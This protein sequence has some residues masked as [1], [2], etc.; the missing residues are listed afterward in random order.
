MAQASIFGTWY[1]SQYGPLTLTGSPENVGGH[2]DQSAGQG[3]I[4][5]GTFNPATGVLAFAYYQSWNDQHGVAGFA[6]S[7]DGTRLEGTWSQPSGHS[8]WNLTRNW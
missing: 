5:Q 7:A 2:W 1:S 4:T 6:L 8:S 3:K